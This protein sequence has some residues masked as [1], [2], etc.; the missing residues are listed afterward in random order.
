MDRQQRRAERAL[1]RNPPI[2]RALAIHE[3]GH[4]VARVITAGVVGWAAGEVIESITAYSAPVAAGLVGLDR[5]HGLRSQVES[6]GRYL[7]RPMQ[8]FV[9]ARQR[10]TLPREAGEGDHAQHGRGGAPQAAPPPP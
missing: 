2:V 4:C 1:A 9:A 7:S 5:Q 6:V 3:A 8:Q 10:T